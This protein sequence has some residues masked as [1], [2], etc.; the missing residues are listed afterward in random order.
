MVVEAK[1]VGAAGGLEERGELAVGAPLE[2]AI[3]GL[4]GEVD[5]A[6]AVGRGAFG[7]FEIA[8]ELFELGAGGEDGGVLG[9]GGGG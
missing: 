5:V 3:V 7:E 4:V 1:A 2:D 9:G 6:F 8:G